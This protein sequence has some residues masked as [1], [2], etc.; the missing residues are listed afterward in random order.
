MI[1]FEDSQGLDQNVWIFKLT[2]AFAVS[3]IPEDMFSHGAARVTLCKIVILVIY[4]PVSSPLC[5]AEMY[6]LL[7]RDSEN[8]SS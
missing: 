1:L 4:F 8:F 7:S 3:V 5:L 2:W 6:I